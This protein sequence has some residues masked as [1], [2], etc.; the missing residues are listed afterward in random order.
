MTSLPSRNRPGTIRALTSAWVAAVL[1][2]V[3]FA[4]TARS[5]T[6]PRPAPGQVPGAASYGDEAI[7]Q[8]LDYFYQAANHHLTFKNG[9]TSG[10]P[11]VDL[12]GILTS[13]PSGVATEHN[14][15]LNERIY[16]RGRD[17]AIWFR[18]VD[19]PGFGP[20]TS[21]GGQAL[22]APSATCRR[23]ASETRVIYVRGLDRALW[24]APHGGRWMRI[25]GTLASAPSATPASAFLGCPSR[26]NVFAL[27][28]DGA[29][30][31]WAGT[32]WHRVGGRSTVAPAAI[33]LFTGETSL[34]VRG[35][36][37]ALWMSKR[38]PGMS[39]WG[40][41]QRIGG[42]LTSSPV[43]TFTQTG[44]SESPGPGTRHVFALG[45]DG[46]LWSIDNQGDGS[47]WGRWAQIP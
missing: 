28:T 21:I 2:V 19:Y 30:W 20:W 23:D 37:D 36:D 14:A 24:R 35:T 40:A 39:T 16:A 6:S 44:S 34:F 26:E 46:N 47:S 32:A 29:V 13:G 45:A 15:F 42:V 3:P 4:G 5:A 22:G 25:G 17:G 27:G 43:V 7:V 11:G 41:W 9:D 8:Q 10:T 31:E 18:Q 1:L 33:E 12:G 38:D